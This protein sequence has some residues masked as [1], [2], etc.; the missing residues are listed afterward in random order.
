MTFVETDDRSRLVL[1]GHRN[2]QYVMRENADGSILLQPAQ[3]VIEAQRE[4]DTTPQ[5]RDTLAQA[6]ASETVS[7]RR[8][9][10]R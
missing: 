5:L 7:R 6:A 3:V 1:P 2:A 8:R 10:R 4:Y 9:S